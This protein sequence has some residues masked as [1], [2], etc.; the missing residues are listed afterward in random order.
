MVNCS[1]DVV[2]FVEWGSRYIGWPIAVDLVRLVE[3]MPASNYNVQSLGVDVVHRGLCPPVHVEVSVHKPQD[4]IMPDL[5]LVEDPSIHEE[6]LV[7]I[8]SLRK[9][10]VSTP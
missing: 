5:E 6:F 3:V 9:F 7:A 10:V 1:G 8:T 2:N 4:F